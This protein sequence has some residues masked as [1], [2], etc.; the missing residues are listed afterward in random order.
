MVPLVENSTSRQAASGAAASAIGLVAPSRT[1]TVS[2]VASVI[3]EAMVRF[4]M[5]S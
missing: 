1:V 3:W 4:Q 5:S 2:P